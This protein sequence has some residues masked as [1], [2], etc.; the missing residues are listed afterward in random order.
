MA[1][2]GMITHD[3]S[4]FLVTGETLDCEIMQIVEMLLSTSTYTY[5]YLHLSCLHPATKCV[6][7][8]HV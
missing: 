5:K 4:I 7:S 8:M 3:H 1:S 6:F 2:L